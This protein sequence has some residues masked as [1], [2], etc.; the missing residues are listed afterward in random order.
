[1]EIKA[2]N[3]KITCPKCFEKYDRIHKSFKGKCVKCGCHFKVNK[4][5]YYQTE[6]IKEK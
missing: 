2:I 5:Y 4:K 1:M 6:E 3:P